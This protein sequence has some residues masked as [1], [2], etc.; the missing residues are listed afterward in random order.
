M[1]VSL[2]G[3]QA[4]AIGYAPNKSRNCPFYIK[5]TNGLTSTF[6]TLEKLRYELRNTWQFSGAEKATKELS[7]LIKGE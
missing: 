6:K 3:L 7:S 4:S 5:S 1:E 2:N